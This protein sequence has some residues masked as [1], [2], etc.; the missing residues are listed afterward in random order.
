MNVVFGDNAAVAALDLSRSNRLTGFIKKKLNDHMHN[1]RVFTCVVIPDFSAQTTLEIERSE[2][3]DSFKII[4]DNPP[5]F[6]CF[7]SRYY[8]AEDEFAKKLRE[9]DFQIDESI[10]MP[11]KGSGTAFMT[12]ESLQSISELKRALK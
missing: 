6:K 10:I 4:R 8:Y 9:L 2:V 1:S 3:V 5:F 7:V 12:L 11:N